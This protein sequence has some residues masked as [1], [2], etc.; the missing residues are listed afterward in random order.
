[1]DLK[2]MKWGW[3]KDPDD[4]RDIPFKAVRL[5]LV[6]IA[7]VVYL[8]KP[9]VKDQGDF[10]SCVFN[11]IIEEMESVM[12]SNDTIPP[13]VLSRMFAY[14]NYRNQYDNI[15]NDSGAFP[16]DALKVI[17]KDGI[18]LE[19]HWQYI[20][21]NFTAK[22]PEECWEEAKKYKIESYHTL[23]SLDDMME[24][25]AEGWPFGCGINI[26]K[27][28]TSKEVAKTGI[29]PMP[30]PGEEW[31][32]GHYVFFWGYDRHK[33][34]FHGQNSWGK[35][36]GKDGSF[37]IPFDYLTNNSFCDDRWTVRTITR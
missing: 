5:G 7:P 29:V 32:G 11:G 9:P 23:N 34:V 27:S 36:W 26:Y 33:Q 35:G 12:I 3:K 30:S 19:E 24:N 20:D 18:C 2:N 28:F 17:A 10:G 15:N 37:T 13:V 31:L 21:K 16:R 14:W 22:P 1:M 8:I 25:V 4:S 6:N